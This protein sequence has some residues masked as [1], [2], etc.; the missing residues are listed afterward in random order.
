MGI[1]GAPTSFEAHVPNSVEGSGVRLEVAERYRSLIAE[2]PEIGR[3]QRTLEPNPFGSDD[4]VDTDLVR[5]TSER[6]WPLVAGSAT[7]MG[8]ALMTVFVVRELHSF[9]AAPVA[10]RD[11]P[12]ESRCCSAAPSV[13]SGWKS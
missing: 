6:A 2:R 12:E 3:R 13:S 1:R 11:S 5:C 4:V 8:R 10:S 7:A 9:A